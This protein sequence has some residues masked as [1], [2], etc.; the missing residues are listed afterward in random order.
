MS[1]ILRIV[2]IVLFSI[3][4]LITLFY[5]AGGKDTIE[6]AAGGKIETY[7]KFTNVLIIWA[8]ILTGLAVGFTVI[9][10]IVQMI[11]NPKNAK[12]GLL[13]IVALVVVLAIAYVLSSS[14]LL[15]ITKPELVKFDTPSTVKYAGMM[16]N[17]IY[18]LAVIAIGSMVYTEASKIFK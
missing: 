8:Y 15:G 17:S 13:G 5:Y 16:I 14:D 18:I 11:T 4:A 12:K 2:L 7:P 9:F 1:K 3:S 6:L 10:P